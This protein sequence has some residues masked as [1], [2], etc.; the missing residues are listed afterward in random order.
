[1]NLLKL[2]LPSTLPIFELDSMEP[3]TVLLQ[4]TISMIALEAELAIVR[5]GLGMAPL[6][7][8]EVATSR[9]GL[10]TEP[11]DVGPLSRVHALV[12]LIIRFVFKQMPANSFR[13]PFIFYDTF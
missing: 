8:A 6:M 13:S 1:M 5:S 11:T 10:L 3:L 2:T 7:F 4:L 9:E 12:H